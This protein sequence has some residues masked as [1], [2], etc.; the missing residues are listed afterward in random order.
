MSASAQAL[1][2]VFQSIRVS[3]RVASM[4]HSLA[5]FRTTATQESLEHAL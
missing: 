1:V 4:R 3:E 5:P 2:I